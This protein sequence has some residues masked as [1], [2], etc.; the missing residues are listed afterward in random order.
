MKRFAHRGQMVE[1][2]DHFSAAKEKIF[3]E[4]IED[5]G[6]DSFAHALTP[7]MALPWFPFL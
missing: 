4:R 7:A 1:T 5:P 6:S 3:G 2:G